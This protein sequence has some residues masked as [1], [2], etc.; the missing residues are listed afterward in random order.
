MAQEFV[1]YQQRHRGQRR[2]PTYEFQQIIYFQECNKNVKGFD[3]ETQETS[4]QLMLG[5]NNSLKLGVC[6]DITCILNS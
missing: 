4:E 2:N 6:V 5:N 3:R 1:Q